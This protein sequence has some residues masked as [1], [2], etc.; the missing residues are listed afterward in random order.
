MTWTPDKLHQT[1]TQLRQR[2]GDTA[3][4]EVKKAQG[5]LPRLGETLCAFANMPDGG[6][7]ILGLDEGNNFKVTGIDQEAKLE[8]AIAAHNRNDVSPSPYLEFTSLAIKDKA[9]EPVRTVLIVEVEGLPI[10]DKPARYK[11]KAYLRQADGDYAM[12]PVELRMLEVAKLHVSEQVRYDTQA[13]ANSKLEDLDPD[14]VTSYINQAKTHS[15]RLQQ[16]SDLEVLRTTG[17]ITADEKPTLAGLYGLGFYPQGPEPALGVTA[18]VLTQRNGNRRSQNLQHFDGA[19]PHLLGDIMRWIESNLPTYQAYQ[20][21]GNLYDYTVLPLSAVREV[22]ANALV[23]RDLSPLS[24]SSGKS[25]QIRITDR[26]LIVENPGGLRGLSTEQILSEEHAQAA[27]NQGLYQLMKNSHTADGARLIEGEGGGIREVQQALAQV[28]APQPAFTDTG[29]KFRV[30]LWFPDQVPLNGRP[31]KQ[32]GP[33]IEHFPSAEALYRPQS[34][35]TSLQALGK[36]VPL[37]AQAL[38]Q[39]E[40]LTRK[41]LALQTKLS[42]AQTRYALEQLLKADLVSMQGKRGKQGTSYI[43]AART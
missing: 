13:V 38:K 20:A 19:L 11:G 24:L 30:I 18:A 2:Q 8:A 29:V 1:L 12:N 23:H 37:V 36:N 17:A 32:E 28:Q 43:W 25:V 6:T 5:G 16:L 27:V 39:G 42:P 4:I 22:I 3:S 31:Q 21:D 41:D 33:H 40:A 7:I 9:H 26:C 15:R 14:L 35:E 10:T 34:K